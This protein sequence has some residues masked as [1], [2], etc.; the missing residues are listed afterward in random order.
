MTVGPGDSLSLVLV[1]SQ[2]VSSGDPYV[3]LPDHIELSLGEAGELLEV[4]DIAATV[5]R[6]DAERAAVNDASHMITINPGWRSRGCIWVFGRGGTPCLRPGGCH[7]VF[8]PGPGRRSLVE[9]SSSTVAFMETTPVSAGQLDYEDSGSGEMIVLVH[10]AVMDTSV[11]DEVVEGLGADLR[12]VRPLLPLGAHR[13][14]MRPNANLSLRGHA[15]IL[16]DFLDRLDL[17]DVTLVFNDW[18]AAQIMIADGLC[19]RVGGLV[20]VSCE[21]DDNYPPGLPGRVL[22]LSGWL[23]GGL[24]LA[25]QALRFKVFQR[26][27]LTLGA[28]SAR[29]LPPALVN[30]WFT[31]MRKDRRVRADL[32]RYVRDTKRG[33][34]DLV[35]ATGALGSFDKPVL[36]IWGADDRV[37]PIRCGRRLASMFPN[38]RFVEVADAR[39]LVPLDQPGVLA[40]EIRAFVDAKTA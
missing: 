29:P 24:V 36:V 13:T 21:T 25:S 19:G 30:R 26:L 6:T 5:A 15:R 38:A 33:R 10:G 40:D 2:A 20:L 17:E 31:P 23:P 37:Q 27:P 7:S 14:A 16:A 1:R 18:C 32:R 4:L 8:S 28:M 12:C 34:A 9:R 22:A 35:A 39:T 3:Q 11:W